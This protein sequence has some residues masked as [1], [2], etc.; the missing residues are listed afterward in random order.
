[1]RSS[2]HLTPLSSDIMRSAEGLAHT[3][4]R[5]VKLLPHPDAE[6]LIKEHGIKLSKAAAALFGLGSHVLGWGRTLK[7]PSS[8]VSQPPIKDLERALRRLEDA[9]GTLGQALE[10]RDLLLEGWTSPNALA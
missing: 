7:S 9:S 10:V 1:M 3:L 8:S 2:D 5:I 4:E 6:A